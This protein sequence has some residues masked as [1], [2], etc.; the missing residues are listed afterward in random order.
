M[1]VELFFLCDSAPLREN[2][3]GILVRLNLTAIIH[4]ILF[5]Q[6]QGTKFRRHI[7]IFQG[8]CNEVVPVPI[9]RNA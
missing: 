6:I 4:E 1:I 8:I 7:S 3:K 9:Y 2:S 5:M